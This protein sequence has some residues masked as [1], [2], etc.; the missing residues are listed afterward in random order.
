MNTSQILGSTHTLGRQPSTTK[1]ATDSFTL[2]G[3]TKE[4][5]LTL[6]NENLD[7]FLN[8]IC[9]LPYSNQLHL[10]RE[11]LRHTTVDFNRIVEHY[12]H[13]QAIKQRVITSCE[14]M[15]SLLLEGRSRESIEILGKVIEE[16]GQD[17]ELYSQTKLGEVFSSVL[18]CSL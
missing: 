17:M 5:L 13:S 18:K 10:L 8:K 2:P 7:L 9:S 3:E 15:R 16:V 6:M 12:L 11:R 14:E 4:G 1:A